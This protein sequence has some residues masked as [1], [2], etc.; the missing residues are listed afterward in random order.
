M[1]KFTEDLHEY[2]KPLWKTDKIVNETFMFVGEEDEAE[3]LFTPTEILSV[4]DYGKTKTYT[5][6]KDYVISGKKI[7]RLS[8]SKIPYIKKDDYYVDTYETFGIGACERICKEYGKQKYLTFGECNTFTDRQIAVTYLKEE[9]WKGS[10]P[11]GKS[12]KFKNTLEKLV[13]GEKIKFLFY[14]DSITTGCNASGMAQGGNVPPYAPP[15]DKQVCDYLTEKY[16]AEIER[17]NTAVGGMNT[18]WGV[19]NLEERV[20]AY[21][22]DIVFI[23]FGMND[24]VTTQKDY[25]DM[26]VDMT[27]R[28]RSA[29]PKAEIMLAS[30]ILPNT[31]ADGGWFANQRLFYE[32]LLAI[33]KRYDFVGTADITT[34]HKDILSAGKRYKDMTGNNINHPNDF[35]IRLYSQVILTTLIGKDFNL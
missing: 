12:E 27:E 8:S 26:I 9:E 21:N 31:E 30:S 18:K 25:E 4:T 24:P 3:F 35:L 2:L 13:K 32:N 19:D 23:A 33:E 17:I 20:I 15:F 11:Q 10:V 16:G 22:P 7:K 29:N 6:G 5:E 28:I 1:E 34:M 14:G